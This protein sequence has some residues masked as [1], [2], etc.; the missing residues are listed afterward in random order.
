MLP[1]DH[2]AQHSRLRSV[3]PYL[4]LLLALGLLIMCLAANNAAFGL[5]VALFMLLALRLA[6]G[7][8]LSYVFALL[9]VPLLFIAV[10]C[11]AIVLDF[12][13]QPLG[14]W[15]LPL[16][17][18]LGYFSATWPGLKAA[19]L[20]FCRAYGAV[21]CLY[22]LSLT[23][24]MQEIIMVLGSLRLPPLVIELMYLIYR[25][26]FLLLDIQHR[27]T[28]AASSRLGY[29]SLRRAWFS[30]TH[31]SGNLLAASFKRSSACLDAMDARCYAGRLRF[32]THS[33]PV[34]PGHAALC[35][36]C[37]FTFSSLAVYLKH[38]GVDLF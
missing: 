34:H 37:L 25:Y 12:S 15:D 3:S 5:A 14:L 18:G 35:L 9:T 21:C 4:K 11:L 20:L 27:M 32:L 16:P 31:I 29:A 2:W 7:V 28:V 1:I 22:F 30:F 6:G 36:L 19:G 17:A 13:P 10:S 38:K 26:I 23:I 33:A 24:P 8:P